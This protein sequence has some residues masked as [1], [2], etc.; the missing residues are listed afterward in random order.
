MGLVKNFPTTGDVNVMVEKVQNIVK[1]MGG[2]GE[3]KKTFYE[4]WGHYPWKTRASL[5][6]CFY[7][8]V[9]QVE[10]ILSSNGKLKL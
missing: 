2:K 9:V 6:R 3:E 10:L 5:L 4:E 1:R 7:I 8:Y